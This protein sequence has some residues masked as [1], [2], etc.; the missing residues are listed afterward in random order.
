MVLFA[1]HL[2]VSNDVYMLTSDVSCTFSTKVRYVLGIPVA[3]ALSVSEKCELIFVCDIIVLM[4]KL[5]RLGL[6]SRQIFIGAWFLLLVAGCA[7]LVSR[8][9]LPCCCRVCPPPLSL[10]WL[11]CGCVS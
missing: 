2:L 3:G 4:H 9:R 5:C 1:L 7:L 8:I 11:R 10:V 6:V